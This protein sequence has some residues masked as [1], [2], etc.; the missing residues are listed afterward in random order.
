M[1]KD[2]RPKVK[3]R[4]SNRVI[5]RRSKLSL[6]VRTRVPAPSAASPDATTKLAPEPASKSRRNRTVHRKIPTPASS[7]VAHPT[8]TVKAT[9]KVPNREVNPT[10][11]AIKAAAPQAPNSFANRI[12]T[13]PHP[14][15]LCLGGVFI[16][17][18][19]FAVHSPKNVARSSH[20][21]DYQLQ[22]TNYQFPPCPN[23]QLPPCRKMQ[24]EFCG[25]RGLSNSGKR[26]ILK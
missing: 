15:F 18:V 10:A 20:L 6:L 11:R 14:S 16:F 13:V 5:I 1:A 19:D 17:V 7:S 23:L 12:P 9:D 25:S 24:V 21:F 2:S 4:A 22:I 8:T 3:A 26:I